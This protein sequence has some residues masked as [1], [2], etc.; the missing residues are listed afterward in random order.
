MIKYIWKKSGDCLVVLSILLF[1][2]KSMK[3]DGAYPK[4][5]DFNKRK[6]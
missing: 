6:R 2:K 4:V 3:D 1:S 5:L